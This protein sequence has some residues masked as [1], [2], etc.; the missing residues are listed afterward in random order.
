MKFAFFGTPSIAVTALE[1]M[2]RHGLV[3]RLVVTN[4]DAPV[5]RKH[6]IT[7]PPAKAWATA[8]NIP[9]FQPETLKNQDDLVPLTSEHFDVFVVF[10]YGKIIP[11]W[12]LALPS[13]G[14]I[15]AHPSLLP[16]LRGASPIRSTL[17][18]DLTAAGVTIIR[19]D[20]ELD[21]GPIL[22]QQAIELTHPLPGRELDAIAANLCG[23]LL[24][25]VMKTLPH[26]TIVA[27]PQD[28]AQTTYCTKITRP[29]GELQI[30]PFNLPTG[31]EAFTTYRK[32]C[33]FDGWPGTFFFHNGKRVKITSATYNT[34]TEQLL[35]ANVI[36]EGK[37]E[38]SWQQYRNDL[39][40]Q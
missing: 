31:P 3:P 17:L 40:K 28:H 20:A 4:P 8:H 26:S 7:P 33:A 34:D 13:Y 12:L 23:T 27:T 5:G 15:N 16:K 25:R 2:K 24:S 22:Y 9:V 35:I 10:A 21:H 30:D 18:Q 29:M 19:M 36:P 1:E 14:T 11:E 32:I 39:H 6:I 38:I 37:K